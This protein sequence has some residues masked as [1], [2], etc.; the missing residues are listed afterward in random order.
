VSEYWGGDS[1]WVKDGWNR[2]E[3]KTEV[4]SKAAGCEEGR[5]VLEGTEEAA[6]QGTK[7]RQGG[8]ENGFVT[9]DED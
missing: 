6:E 1:G 4:W 2:V 7:S 3:G 8:A 9:V 5:E